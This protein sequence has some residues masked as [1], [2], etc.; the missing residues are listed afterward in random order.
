MPFTDLQIWERL[1]KNVSRFRRDS[2]SIQLIAGRFSGINRRDMLNILRIDLIRRLNLH[3]LI[4]TDRGSPH[5][6][7]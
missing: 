1:L 3:I 6:F 7:H 2:R 5:L 4:S